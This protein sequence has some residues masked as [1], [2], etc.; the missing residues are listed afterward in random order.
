VR[1][2]RADARQARELSDEVFDGGAEHQPYCADMPRIA[3]VAPLSGSRRMCR[4]LAR[5]AAYT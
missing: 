2:P 4:R 3:K 5:E 1:R